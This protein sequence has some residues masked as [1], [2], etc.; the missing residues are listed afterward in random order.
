[1]I[2]LIYLSYSATDLSINDL[3]AMLETSRANNQENDITGLLLYYERDFL[4]ILEGEETAVMET[5]N[6]ILCDPRHRG[7]IILDQST[8]DHRDFEG[9]SMGFQRLTKDM[10]PAGFIDF[11]SRSFDIGNIVTRGTEAFLFLLSFKNGTQ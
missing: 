7:I 5:F 3:D 10:A 11:F 2:H 8:I 9:W 4:Q 6:R 1:M